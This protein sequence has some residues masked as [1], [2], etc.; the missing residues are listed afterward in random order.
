MVENT[1]GKKYLPKFVYIN[2]LQ[3]QSSEEYKISDEGVVICI[4]FSITDVQTTFKQG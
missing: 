4:Y 1:Y 2:M 3:T